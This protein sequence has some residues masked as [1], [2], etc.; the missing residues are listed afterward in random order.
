MVDPEVELRG[1]IFFLLALPPFLP[2]MIF[3]FYKGGGGR[4]FS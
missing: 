2:S 4:T 1:G 3:P